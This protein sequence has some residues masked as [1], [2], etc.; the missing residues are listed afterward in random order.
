MVTFFLVHFIEEF[1]QELIGDGAGAGT[2]GRRAWWGIAQPQTRTN[3]AW[4]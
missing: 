1:N 2:G 3:T 4:E